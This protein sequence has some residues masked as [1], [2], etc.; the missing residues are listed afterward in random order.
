M[1]LGCHTRGCRHKLQATGY[2]DLETGEDRGPQ[3]SF[4]ELTE[5]AD[6]LLPL[7]VCSACK[8]AGGVN[9]AEGIAAILEAVR[10]VRARAPE[11]A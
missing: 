6:K 8:Q 11:V 2:L 5:E 3:V 10:H 7:G 1:C 4:A 9:R